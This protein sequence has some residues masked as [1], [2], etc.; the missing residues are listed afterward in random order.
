MYCV[1]CEMDVKNERDAVGMSPTP[2]QG[3]SSMRVLPAPGVPGHAAPV[4]VVARLQV[5]EGVL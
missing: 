1:C 4:R 3:M 2:P 5:A